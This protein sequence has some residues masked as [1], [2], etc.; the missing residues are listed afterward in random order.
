MS[1]VKKGH[2]ADHYMS[3]SRWLT[4]LSLLLVLVIIALSS[5]RVERLASYRRLILDPHAT[6]QLAIQP[7]SMH[8]QTVPDTQLIDTFYSQFQ[9]PD[10][11]FTNLDAR[12]TW[13]KLH[14]ANGDSVLLTQLHY[15]T[16]FTA[17]GNYTFNRQSLNEQ[18]KSSWQVLLMPEGEYA[19]HWKLIAA[20]I[21][22]SHADQDVFTFHT[23]TTKGIIRYLSTTTGPHVVNL[24]IWDI[25]R[26]IS[27]E[28]FITIA[29][30]ELRYSTVETIASSYRFTIGAIPPVD[31]QQQ[32]ADDASKSFR[33]H[34]E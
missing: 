14:N 21:A 9:V 27:Q 1:T 22:T 17:D 18:A 8:P 24:V 25:S 33:S 26:P 2:P 5:P 11:F 31:I 16:H 12:K 20:K 15:E 29:D 3:R 4:V 13:L 28:I 34:I 30:P 6:P 19:E 10:G 23:S 32:L 7:K